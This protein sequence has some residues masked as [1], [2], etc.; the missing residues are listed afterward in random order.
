MSTGAIPPRR[1]A[2]RALAL[3]ALVLLLP[4]CEAPEAGS[5]AG[6]E[7]EYG[8]T[9]VLAG[10]A[11]LGPLNP[12][13][14]GE[15]VTQQILEHALFLT[16]LDLD[17]E[18]TPGPAL[19][20][21]WEMEGDSAVVFRLRRDVS[22]HD[23]VPTSARDV[24]FTWERA[25]DPASAYPY[26]GRFEGWTRVEAVDS[27]TVR[28]T[29]EPRPEALMTWALT[30]IVP[31]HLLDGVPAAQ[32]GT[33]A[34]NR[35]PVGNGPFRFVEWRANDRLV[36]EA[37]PDFP[38]ELGGRPYLDRVVYRVIPELSTQLA[39]LS[40]GQ[41]DL[42]LNVSAA[43]VERVARRR[44]VIEGPMQ[45]FAFVGWN[46]RREPLG[47]A[48]VRRA[49]TMAIDREAMTR[50]VRGGYGRAAFGPVPPGHWAFA[51]E[52][53]PLPFD[54][55]AARALLDEMGWTD[56]DGDG[57]REGPDGTPFRFELK[58]VQDPALSAIAE[59]VRSDL[60][61]IGVDV[62]LRLTEGSTLIGQIMDPA[63]EFDAFLLSW[64]VEERIDLRPLFHSA[65]VG[66][67]MQ[68]S[69]YG[70]PRVD[71]LIAR[72]EQPLPQEAA[73]PLWVELQEILRREQPWTF[74]YYF[75]VLSAISDRLQGVEMDLRGQLATLPTWWVAGARPATSTA[76]P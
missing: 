11:D 71:E 60:E 16:L 29:V 43:D 50:L 21:S 63:R 13:I 33:A 53:E 62:E 15:Y 24:V 41:V 2:P 51:E 65:S 73:L 46:G 45:Q 38:E 39:E 28:M 20:D 52:L 69:S 31:A 23:G 14:A 37:N 1:R 6:E 8:G 22:W 66:T 34:F 48:A 49:L 61:R 56:R 67:P 35:R 30:P 40:T 19:A 32:L 12:L 54:T 72:L 5:P 75:S 76:S 74:L 64:N 7:P 57:V 70:N 17:E 9:A 10:N 27:F 58:Y 55:A 68:V 4:G 18:L 3:V 59:L 36:L 26:P 44:R 25:T 42:V 47:S